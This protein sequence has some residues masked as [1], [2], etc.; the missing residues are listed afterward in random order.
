MANGQM[1]QFHITINP[2]FFINA[3]A[4]GI[5][6]FNT[7]KQ[8]ISDLLRTLTVDYHHGDLFFAVT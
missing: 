2:D 1:R 3:I 7:D 8:L 4:V 6:G 5:D